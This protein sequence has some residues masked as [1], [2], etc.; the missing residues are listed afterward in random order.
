LNRV[1]NEFLHWAKD[2][3]DRVDSDNSFGFMLSE[4]DTSIAEKELSK[5]DSDIVAQIS[6]RYT[7]FSKVL[8]KLEEYGKESASTYQSTT[9]ELESSKLKLE[10]SLAGR[11]ARYNAEVQR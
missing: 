7:E 8:H 5:S 11:R 2:T 4:A 1:S 10:T 9:N 6:E 3:I